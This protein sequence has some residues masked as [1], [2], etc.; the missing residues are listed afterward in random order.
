MWK[1]EKGFTPREYGNNLSNPYLENK[2][3]GKCVRCWWFRHARAQLHD[4]SN[5]STT[6]KKAMATSP[7]TWR[8]QKEK[9]II[10]PV[11]KETHYILWHPLREQSSLSISQ[12][13]ETWTMRTKNTVYIKQQDSHL[14]KTLKSLKQ[15][16]YSLSGI[17]ARCILEFTTRYKQA[18]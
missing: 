7:I 12:K 1:C 13:E 10:P 3:T 16:L 11:C 8:N 17:I 6:P 14:A 9:V 5:N 15:E 18:Q 2:N 4:S